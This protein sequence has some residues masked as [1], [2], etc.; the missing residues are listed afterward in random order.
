M[1]INRTNTFFL[2][3]EKRELKIKKKRPSNARLVDLDLLQNKAI[4]KEEAKLYSKVTQQLSYAE[5][6]EEGSGKFVFTGIVFNKKNLFNICKGI[7]GTGFC[8]YFQ[9]LDILGLNESTLFIDI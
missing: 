1:F 8:S 2:V 9:A 7:V 5:G 4:L 3:L 6:A